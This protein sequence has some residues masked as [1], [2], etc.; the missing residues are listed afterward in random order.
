MLPHTRLLGIY[1]VG[2]KMYPAGVVLI[3]R[4]I[5]NT[6]ILAWSVSSILKSCK[7]DDDAGQPLNLSQE[8]RK[9]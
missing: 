1:T 8:H 3:T 5:R 2:I 4:M 7:A 6:L 9:K